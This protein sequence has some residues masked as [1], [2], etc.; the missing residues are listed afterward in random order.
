MIQQIANVIRSASKFLIIPHIN[1]DGDCLGSAFALSLALKKLNKQAI[2][3]LEEELPKMYSFLPG[4]YIKLDKLTKDNNPDVVICVDCS[5]EGR[6]NKR[7]NFLKECEH[8]INLDHHI[9]NTMFAKYNY[10][11]TKASATGEVIF[12]LITKILEIPMD[13]EMAENL[14]VAIATD[15]GGFR[16]SNTT[17]GTHKI[18]SNIL[19]NNINL[20]EINRIIFD[21]VTM[22]K[23]KVTCKAIEKTEF[24]ANGRIAVTIL[25]YHTI[26]NTGGKESDCDG[27]SNLLRSIEGVEVGIFIKEKERNEIKVSF[28]SNKYVDVSKI[29]LKFG[30]GGHKHASGCVMKDTGILFAK[31]KIIEAVTH[32]VMDYE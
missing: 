7:I 24:F 32:A 20:A 19:E 21:T 25:D 1:V 15:T 28:R 13:R 26:I 3:V 23:L 16:Y 11:D 27:L 18:I 10:V 12:K 5:D 29:A 14:Y 9:S 17:P 8:T 31:Q 22:G 2:V 6:V 4:E 30:G